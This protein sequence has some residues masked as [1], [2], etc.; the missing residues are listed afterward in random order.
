MRLR[1]AETTM[2]GDLFSPG[3]MGV[4]TL[5]TV[6]GLFYLLGK[7]AIC[8]LVRRSVRRKHP[9]L[10]EPVARLGFYLTILVGIGIGMRAGGYGNALT[11]LGAVAAAGTVAIGFAMKDTINAAVSGFFLLTDKPFEKGD[12]I[13]WDGYKGTVKEIRIRTTLVETF[14]NELL[15]VPNSELANNT[16]KNPV[17]NDRLRVKIVFGIGYEDG[18]EQA[19]TCIQEILEDTDEIA[20]DPAPDVKLTGLGDSAVELTARYWIDDPKRGAFV[21][22][23]DSILQQVKQ[24]FDEEGIDMPYPTRTIAG[25]PP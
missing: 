4:V 8:P 19:K 15:T 6:S 12:W 7:L 18:I 22:A 21:T 9:T 17:A 14:D 3:L 11:V 1:V 25:E 23:R 2:T 24:R 16:V 10:A 20:T 13:E 5:V